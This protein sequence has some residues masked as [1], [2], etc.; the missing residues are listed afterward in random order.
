[1]GDPLKIIR[2]AAMTVT[3]DGTDLG[4]TT[5]GQEVNRDQ[6][7]FEVEVDQE[8]APVGADIIGEKIDIS[9]VLAESSKEALAIYFNA[10][11]TGAAPATI[12][13]NFGGTTTLQHG[14]LILDTIKS[15]TISGTEYKIRFTFYD[16][17]AKPNGSLKYAKGAIA[18]VPLKF[19][20][21][22]QTDHSD[23][24]TLGKYE[25]VAV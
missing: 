2:R 8:L 7:E 6:Q 14:Q 23:G 18:G 25:F 22:A 21:L 19:V 15:V 9:L 3:L 24:Q 13:G 1:M 12:T 11:N 20:C 17:Y 10:V 4:Y 5:G 16:A